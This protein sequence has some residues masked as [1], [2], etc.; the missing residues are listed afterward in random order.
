MHVRSRGARRASIVVILGA[1]LAG[2]TGAPGTAH[3]DW[4]QFHNTVERRGVTRDSGLSRS[5]ARDLQIVWS[6]ATGATTEGVNSSPAVVNGVVYIGSD[7][8]KLWALDAATGAPIWSQ[9]T[10]GMVRS[11]PAVVGGIVYIGSNGGNLLAFDAV[12]GAPIWTTVL[13]GQVAAPVVSGGRVFVGTRGGYFYALDAATG[14]VLWSHRIWAVWESAALHGDT[15]YVGSDQ[16]KLWA[17][18]SATGDLKWSTTFDGRVRCSPSF[19]RGQLYVGDDSGKVSALDAHTGDLLW[20]SEAA[21]PETNAI[22]RS[23]PAVGR[24]L[25]YVDTGETTPMDG[26]VVAFDRTTGAEVWRS[27]M[28][29][30]ATSS[31]AL[32]NRVLYVGSFDSRLYA[33]DADSGQELWTSGWGTFSA[34][35]PSS[36][37]VTGGRV[38]VGIRDGSVVAFGI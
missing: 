12:T 4:S 1:M 31:P 33:Y 24:G 2:A 32:A 18:D 5:D 21:P 23:A 9:P 11:S 34:S 17:Y 37:A 6:T 38:Y 35:I 20:T 36:P 27:H 7:D 8:G 25:V 10:G 30:Y 29:D 13:G 19:A 22:V 3:A 16:Y 28:A 15:V 14:A 26:H